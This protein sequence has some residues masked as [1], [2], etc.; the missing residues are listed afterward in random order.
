VKR[1]DSD[2]TFQSYDC[3]SRSSTLS[4][5]VNGKPVL[6]N[7]S[8]DVTNNIK[9]IDLEEEDG[10]STTAYFSSDE[11]SSL[12]G[13]ESIEAGINNL[14]VIFNRFPAKTEASDSGNKMS[15]ANPHYLCPEVRS[16]VEKRRGGATNVFGENMLAAAKDSSE[17]SSHQHFAQALN[18]PADSLFSDY[19]VI[20]QKQKQNSTFLLP[21]KNLF[22]LRFSQTSLVG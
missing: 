7:K 10:A 16:I 21:E 4:S 5:S 15:F 18:S 19:Q 11:F 1:S 14:N 3:S 13:Y 22:Y 2:Y 17:S 9:L 12:S 20:L 8:G 6:S